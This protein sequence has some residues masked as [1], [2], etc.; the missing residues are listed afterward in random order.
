MRNY[1]AHPAAIATGKEEDGLKRTRR[2]EI[3]RYSRRVTVYRSTSPAADPGAVKPED[4]LILEALAV[5]TQFPL[6][7][8]SCDGEATDDAVSDHAPRRRLLS[9]LGDLLRLRR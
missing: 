5:I 6:A 9:S 3:T 8:L 1:R 2:I 4:D 7:P